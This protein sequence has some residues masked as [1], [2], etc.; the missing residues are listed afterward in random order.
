[1]S[2]RVTVDV[3][4]SLD[5]LVDGCTVELSKFDTETLR[6]MAAERES[7]RASCWVAQMIRE[8]VSVWRAESSS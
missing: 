1:M 7:I 6:A 3:R 4:R 8:Y 2:E 5:E